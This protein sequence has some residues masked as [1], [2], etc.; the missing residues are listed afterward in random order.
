MTSLLPTNPFPG[1][2]PYLECAG[3][4]PDV[5]NSIIVGLRDFLAARL[6]PE[7]VVR[8]QQR[9]YVSAASD[10]NGH[11]QHRIPD[12]IVLAGTAPAPGISGGA[13]PAPARTAKPDTDTDAIAVQIPSVELEQQHY[14]EVLRVGNR[15]VIAVIELLSPANKWGDGRQEYL[16]KRAAVKISTAHLVEIDLLRAGAPMPVIGD[17]PARSYRIL[18]RDARRSPAADLYPFGIRQPIPDFVLP[19]AE[20]SE[21][22]GVDLNRVVSGVYVAGAYWLD[23]DYRDD[24]EPP[25]SDDDRRW[26]DALLRAQG[27]R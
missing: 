17:V 10:G 2:N 4:W 27:L 19:L 5:H 12:A 25:L 7:Y 18:V 14:L 8:M 6:Q 24:P 23:I 13:T 11:P 20:G 21:G 3:L 9:V 16:A 26:L 1:M 22:V 15:E